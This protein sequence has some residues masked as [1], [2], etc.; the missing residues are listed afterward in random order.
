[1]SK[2][3]PQVNFRLPASLRERLQYSA[4][5]AKR[6]LTAEMITRLEQSFA[7]SEEEIV[8]RHLPQSDLQ[9]ILDRLDKQQRDIDAIGGKVGVATK[10][11]L[12]GKLK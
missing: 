6:T 11:K 8:R 5:E 1:M 9:Q 3:D 7:R 10:P 12:K 2:T 4:A